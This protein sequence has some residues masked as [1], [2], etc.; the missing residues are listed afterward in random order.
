MF[1]IK[2]FTHSDFRIAPRERDT[3]KGDYGRARIVAGSFEMPGAALLSCA[4]AKAALR[5]GAGLVSL[6]VPESMKETYAARA[7]EYTLRFL[8]DIGGKIVFDEQAARGI[9]DGA[10]AIAMG[11]GMGAN[12]AI[13]DYIRFFCS[14]QCTVHSPQLNDNAQCH[15]H[16]SLS[17]PVTD[18]PSKENSPAK[19]EISVGEQSERTPCPSERSEESHPIQGAI[20]NARLKEKSETVDCGLCAV[21][22]NTRPFTLILDADAL[23]AL[24]ADMS[25]LRVENRKAQIIITP[26]CAEFCR[27]WNAAAAQFKKESETFNFQLPTSD[28]KETF[29]SQLSTSNLK[30]LPDRIRY[31]RAF[32]AA[33]GVTV[34]LKGAD[35]VITDG[36]EAVINTAGTPALA[37]GGS[38]DLLSGILAAFACRHAPLTAAAYACYTLGTA[39]E[40]AAQVFG[41]NSL[42]ASDVPD[43]IRF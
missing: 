6:C 42:L 21:D 26:H 13:L 14:P 15:G 4:A 30:G 3:H 5:S 29:N 7:L 25:V 22:C 41:E 1:T 28:L 17:L 31:A 9:A 39:A 12:P 2:Y 43:F 36:K 38:G 37:K 35:T 8:P 16:F 40:K 33:F 11:M 27:L 32:A 20:R 24:S 19:K 23:N 10:D 34:V 18:C